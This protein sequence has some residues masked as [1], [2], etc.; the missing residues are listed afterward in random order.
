MID[1]SKPLNFSDFELDPRCLTVLQEMKITDPSPVQ[2]Q[3]IPAAL[4]GRD[5][6]AT[7]QTGTGKTLAFSLPSLTRLARKKS[8]SN[9]MLVL[10][11]TRELCAQV[12]S[13]MQALCKPFKMHSVAVY[14]GVGMHGQIEKLTRGCE[15]IVAT[16]GRLLDHLS[17]KN[18]NFE[19]L[20]ILVFDEADRMLD[21]GFLPDIRKIVKLLPQKRQTL[22]FSATFAPTLDRLA[23]D[24]MHSPERIEVGFTAKPVA[25]VRQLVIPVREDEK[26]RILLQLM[27]E[28]SIDSA[29]IFLRTI[30]RTER[31]GRAL[32]GSKHK[33]A[34]IHGDLP[35]TQRQR[36]LEGFRSR[37]YKILVAT[38]VAAR[39]LDIDDISHVINYDIPEN[40]DDYVHRI[41]RTARAER[42]GDAITL[43][44]PNDHAALAA[45]EQALGYNIE[46]RIYD[47][48]PKILSIYKPPDLAA[49]SVVPKRRR[50][51]SLLRRR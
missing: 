30:R 29:L 6:V 27:E 37:K 7:A 36:A 20:E 19:H 39:G 15:I 3:A 12:E 51:R 25:S 40:P 32:K 17:R 33:T 41:G 22:M 18:L 43:V 9:R 11:P 14:G 13:V 1:T 49:R 38:D 48:A 45:I 28:E 8:G 47:G 2:A 44:T 50:G 4:E 10:A 24:M 16:P 42:E 23:R 46:R 21:M 5:I 34:I 31:V 35:Q 26:P